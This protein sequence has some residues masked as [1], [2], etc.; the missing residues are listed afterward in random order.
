[1]ELMNISTEVEA[2]AVARSIIKDIG[3]NVLLMNTGYTYKH[4]EMMFHNITASKRKREDKP[5][6]HILRLVMQC[7]GYKSKA[8]ILDMNFNVYITIKPEDQ[9]INVSFLPNGNINGGE[10][11]SFTIDRQ[12]IYRHYDY[13]KLALS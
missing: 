1:M 12:V 10:S 6:Y 13:F 7:T 5:K 4:D 3:L 2:E 8:K 11:L 9:D